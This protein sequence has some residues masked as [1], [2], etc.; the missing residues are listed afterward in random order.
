MDLFFPHFEME[1][2]IQFMCDLF[3][4]SAVNCVFV[5]SVFL[6]CGNQMNLH[7]CFCKTLLGS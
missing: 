5:I 3:I 6:L 7:S 1:F 4:N 2:V